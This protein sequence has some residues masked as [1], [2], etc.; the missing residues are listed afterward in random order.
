MPIIIGLGYRNYVHQEIDKEVLGALAYRD[1]CR[2]SM[3]SV[4]LCLLRVYMYVQCM[5]VCILKLRHG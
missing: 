2:C 4:C 3:Y 1:F 5:N